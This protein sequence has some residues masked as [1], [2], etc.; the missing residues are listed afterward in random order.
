MKLVA[1]IAAALAAVA[2]ATPAFACGM[3]KATKSAE[4]AEAKPA[5][6][7]TAGEKATAQKAKAA[8]VKKATEA[9]PV[10]A[11]N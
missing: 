6:A 2:L 10:T 9:K 1:R 8:P 7:S 3:E 11:Q 5:V 4:K